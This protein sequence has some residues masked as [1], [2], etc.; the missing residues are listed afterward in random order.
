MPPTTAT[1]GAGGLPVAAGERPEGSLYGRRG[2]KGTGKG[3]GGGDADSTGSGG[4]RVAS[5]ASIKTLPQPLEDY[6]HLSR[7][8]PEEAR[9]AGVEGDVIVRILVDENGRVA[10]VTLVK[11]AGFGLDRKALDIARRMR[12]RP[13]RDTADRAVAYR[14]TWTFHF[15]LPD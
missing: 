12:F 5:I 4:P 8:Y 7:E 13:A 14:I 2:G 6:S 15:T 9:R 3:G 10:E 11:G 1:P